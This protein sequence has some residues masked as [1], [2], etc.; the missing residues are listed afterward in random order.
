MKAILASE[1]ALWFVRNFNFL[2]LSHD[3]R[4][5]LVRLSLERLAGMAKPGARI[6]VLLENVSKLENNPNELFLRG[7]YNELIRDQCERIDNLTYLDV[8]SAS[9]IE[10]LWD[11]GFHMHRQG[12]YEL[13]QS[14][15]R[16]IESGG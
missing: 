1:Q 9:S 16:L 14:V 13:A 3:Q 8:N 15:M 6:I 11:D 7:L 4:Q 10:W 2:E 5:D 12:Y